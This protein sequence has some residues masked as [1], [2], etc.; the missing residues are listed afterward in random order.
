MKIKRSW[1]KMAY[2][3]V[4]VALSLFVAA[5]LIRERPDTDTETGFNTAS[6]LLAILA[7]AVIFALAYAKNT[8]CSLFYELDMAYFFQDLKIKVIPCGKPS[9]G[10]VSLV[11]DLRSL[12]LGDT[13]VTLQERRTE[14]FCEEHDPRRPQMQSWLSRNGIEVEMN[15]LKMFRFI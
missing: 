9:V 12:N 4:A 13:T 6:Q 7:V 10:K 1:L 8:N 3:I 11:Q 14:Y 5:V 2:F 15:T